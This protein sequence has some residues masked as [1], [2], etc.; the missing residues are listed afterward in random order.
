MTRPNLVLKAT[1]TYWIIGIWK[2]GWFD[3]WLKGFVGFFGLEA[4]QGGESGER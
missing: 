2:L 4:L 1:A 3:Y